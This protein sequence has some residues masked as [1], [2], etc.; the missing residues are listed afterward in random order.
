[1][2]A[3]ACKH[4][5]ICCRILETELVEACNLG[6]TATGC[7]PE[8]HAK[9]TACKLLDMPLVAMVSPWTSSRL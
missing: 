2:S 4:P 9:S 1:M 6:F 3:Q 5:V 8:H 7:R